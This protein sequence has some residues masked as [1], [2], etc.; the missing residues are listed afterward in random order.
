MVSCCITLW[1]PEENHEKKNSEK[2][3]HFYDSEMINSKKTL[4]FT[5]FL[6]E[7]CQNVIVWLLLLLCLVLFFPVG[8]FLDQVGDAVAFEASVP[9]VFVFLLLVLGR[10]GR[11]AVLP[12]LPVLVRARRRSLF[13]SGRVRLG[14]VALPVFL[15]LPF[16]SCVRLVP[17]DALAVCLRVLIARR[18]FTARR[19]IIIR[20]SWNVCRVWWAPAV[21][22][23]L[24]V[25]VFISKPSVVCSVRRP[26][27][28]R[29]LRYFDVRT[30]P[31]VQNINK[32][33][34][35]LILPDGLVGEIWVI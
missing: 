9:P 1:I 20:R 5:W 13:V 14:Q 12:L 31:C 28:L 26:R 10:V 23:N 6:E 17:V 11:L 7:F 4:D 2:N 34:V 18:I 25:W 24:V 30:G 22:T 19:N 21:W 27:S 15:I 16:A 8:S 3:E 29:F 35:K 32:K 33:A